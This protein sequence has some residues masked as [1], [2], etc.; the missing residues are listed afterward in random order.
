M[1]AA[2]VERYGGPEVVH[3]SDVPRPEPGGDQVLVRVH[4]VAVTSGDAR[5]RGARFPA[6]FAVFG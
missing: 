6:G 4:A 1:R 3:I 2:V 5:I